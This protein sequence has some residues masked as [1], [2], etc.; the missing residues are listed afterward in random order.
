MES[1]KSP[2]GEFA[3]R[4]DVPRDRRNILGWHVDSSYYKNLS[5]TGSGALISWIALCDVKIKNGAIK[6][7]LQSHKNE[8][9]KTKKHYTNE[10]LF[11]IEK[12][13]LLIK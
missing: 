5:K 11:Q 10:T 9:F 7:C 4:I 6:L 2:K 8:S 13:R 12:N 1:M 3:G